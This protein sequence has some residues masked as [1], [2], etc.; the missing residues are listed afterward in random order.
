MSSKLYIRDVGRTF[1]SACWP[2]GQD[3]FATTCEVADASLGLWSR[4]SRRDGADALQLIDNE[5]PTR[6]PNSH[7]RWGPNSMHATG[8]HTA[9]NAPVRADALVWV[10]E[11]IYR[12]A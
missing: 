3:S 6:D 7:T 9:W 11:G 10:G 2:W 8:S 5:Q 12:I 4:G 1:A